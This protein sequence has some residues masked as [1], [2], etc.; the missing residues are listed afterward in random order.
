MNAAAPARHVPPRVSIVVPAYNCARFLASTVAS[1]QAQSFGRW[2][3]VVFDDGSTDATAHVAGKFA[4]ADP[5]VRLVHGTNGGVAAARNRGF[6]ATDRRSEFAIFLDHDDVWEPD[7]LETLLGVLDSRH[8]LVAA[9]CVARCVDGHGR[10]TAGDD[11]AERLRERRG[12]RAGRVAPLSR[13]E[14][15]TFADLVFE[16]WILTP[17]TTLIRRQVIEAIGGFDPDTVPADDWD[18]ALRVSRCGEIG[19]VDLPLLLWRRHAE[20][21]S[22]SSPHWRRA[23]FRVRAKALADPANTAEQTH[24]ARV[25]YRE[26]CHSMLGEARTSVAGGHLRRAV[27]PSVASLHRYLMYGRAEAP[28]LWRQ[29]C[30][31]VRGRTT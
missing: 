27:R 19:F 22:T 23:Y 9:H 28:L 29:L 6:A 18:M 16:N 30:V 7:L 13:R 31:R 2:E 20:D 24:A 10:P 14:S 17:G 11:L 1:V 4:E 8:A 5:R 15:T 26:I 12:L 25:A 21:Q 3:L